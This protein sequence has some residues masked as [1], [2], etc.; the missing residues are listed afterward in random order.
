MLRHRLLVGMLLIAAFAGLC[1]LDKTR[2]LGAAA[3]AWLFPVALLL[4]LAASGEMLNLVASDERQPI[5]W[6]VYAGNFLIVAANGVPAF[7]PA[8]W[9]NIALGNFGW[10]MVAFSVS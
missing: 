7:G 1:W 8:G 9:N 4:S 5:R 3:G 10:P 2:A 6:L